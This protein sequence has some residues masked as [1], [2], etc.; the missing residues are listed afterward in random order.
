M[1]G[2]ILHRAAITGYLAFGGT[3]G[4]TLNVTH[5]HR[6]DFVHVK[7]RREDLVPWSMDEAVCSCAWCTTRHNGGTLVGHVPDAPPI[8]DGHHAGPRVVPRF[9]PGS[10]M[11]HVSAAHR[12]R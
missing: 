2:H 9:G 6:L 7:R 8:R 1:L 11:T 10:V 3:D 5:R 4:N 12:D